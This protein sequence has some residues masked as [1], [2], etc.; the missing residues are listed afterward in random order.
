MEVRIV[1][2]GERVTDVQAKTH[3][4]PWTTCPGAEQ[5]IRDLIGT[6]LQRMSQS[7]GLDS[8]EHCTHLYDVA[9]L[10]IA[11]A[12]MKAPVQY[13][14]TIPDRIEKRTCAEVLRDGKLCLTWDIDGDVVTG[15]ARFAG[16]HVFGAPK[17]PADLD[18]DTLEAAMVVRRSIFVSRAR[19]AL[20]KDMRVNDATDA[21]IIQRIRDR[22]PLG[23]CFTYQEGVLD[24]ARRTFSWRD[25]NGRQEELLDDFAGTRRIADMAKS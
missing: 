10:T 25:H 4:V 2:D 13:D 17:W 16:H 11:R 21:E 3:R 24:D 8:K 12:F 20:G 6:P 5:K 15:P 14:I 7:T 1:H 19:S 22:G 23:L 9:R 18:E